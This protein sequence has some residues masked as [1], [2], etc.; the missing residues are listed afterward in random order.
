MRIELERRAGV[1]K[2]FSILSPFI[3]LGLTLMLGGIMFMMRRQGP[4]LQRF[5]ASLSSL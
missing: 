2:L 4:R 3:A 1:S 5:T